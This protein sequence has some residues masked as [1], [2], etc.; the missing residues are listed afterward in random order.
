[1]HTTLLES[2]QKLSDFPVPDKGLTAYDVQME[3]T[4]MVHQG[5]HFVDQPISLEFVKLGERSAFSEMEIPIGI[6]A[7]AG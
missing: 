2:R 1:M 4:V 3:R 5:Q 6:A 7:R